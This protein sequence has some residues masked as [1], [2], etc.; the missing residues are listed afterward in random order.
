MHN[1][2]IMN[3]YCTIYIWSLTENC[4]KRFLLGQAKAWDKLQVERPGRDLRSNG[5]EPDTR[6][7]L[8]FESIKKFKLNQIEPNKYN[9]T[10]DTA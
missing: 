7:P 6:P 9:C 4:L 5:R 2:H 8:V 1:I 3:I 10:V